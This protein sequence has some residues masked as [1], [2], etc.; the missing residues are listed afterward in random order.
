MRESTIARVK[1]GISPSLSY[2]TSKRLHSR[3]LIS[4]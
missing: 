2:V 3:R 1:Y 4:C